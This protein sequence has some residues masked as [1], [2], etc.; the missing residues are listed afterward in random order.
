MWQPI[1][2]APKDGIAVLV[3]PPTWQRMGAAIAVWDT[4]Q[5]ANKPRPFW[6]R[7][8]DMGRTTTSRC[9]PPTHWHPLPEP[10]AD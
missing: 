1:E 9:N 4:D 6:R 7:I 2:T 5:C 3:Y 10:P 8:D